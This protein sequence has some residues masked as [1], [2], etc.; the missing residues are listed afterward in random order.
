MNQPVPQ[1]VRQRSIAKFSRIPVT[2]FF[3]AF[4]VIQTA[5]ADVVVLKADRVNIRNAPSTD[6]EVLAWFKRGETVETRGP[7]GNGWLKIAL[8]PKLPVWAYGALVDKAKGKVRAKELNLRNGPG[9]NYVEIGKLSQGDSVT[10]IRESDGWV[11]IEP[12]AGVSAYVSANLLNGAAPAE[13]VETKSN[14]T[15]LAEQ[16]PPPKAKA[17]ETVRAESSNSQSTIVA[18][19]AEPSL[20]PQTTIVT[21]TPPPTPPPASQPVSSQAFYTTP[22]PPRKVV[23]SAQPLIR[24]SE[25]VRRVVRVGRVGLNLDPKSPSYYE[26]ESLNKGEGSLGYLVSNDGEIKF[27]PYRDRIVRITADEY[28]D[29]RYPNTATLDVKTIKGDVAH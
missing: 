11:Q 16:S 7:A 20:P 9:K 21:T 12:P 19:S 14:G 29:S 1:A 3:A 26:L 23:E 13:V 10:V 24:Y 22:E 28:L 18:K 15:T 25:N 17:V 4:G 8:P 6:G 2:L 27:G 5:T